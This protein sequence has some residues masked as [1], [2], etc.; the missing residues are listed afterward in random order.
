[1]EYLSSI[2]IASEIFQQNFRANQNQTH[3][4]EQPSCYTET[5]F[6]VRVMIQGIA[7]T[8]EIDIHHNQPL[9]LDHLQFQDDVISLVFD[10]FLSMKNSTRTELHRVQ[11]RLSFKK[12]MSF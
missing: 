3:P 12:T 1:M 2:G 5:I 9:I 4:Q 8:Q 7:Q 10:V 11:D 6:H